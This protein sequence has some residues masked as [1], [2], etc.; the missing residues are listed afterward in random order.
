MNNKT[1]SKCNSP[2]DEGFLYVTNSGDPS[3]FNY[4][5]WAKGTK[6]TLTSFMGSNASAP[7]FP[8]RVYKCQACNHL[9]FYTDEPQ[10]WKH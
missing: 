2:L 8:V 10:K 3:F 7:Q 1:C 6:E 5:V 4:V 9:D